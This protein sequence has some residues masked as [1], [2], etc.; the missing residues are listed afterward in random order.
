MRV[1][2][3]AGIF[4]GEGEMIQTDAKRVEVILARRVRIGSKQGDEQASHRHEHRSLGFP[5]QRAAEGVHVKAFG[6]RQIGDAQTQMAP[7]VG[8]QLHGALEHHGNLAQVPF[9]QKT[10]RHGFSCPNHQFVTKMW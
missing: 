9:P 4:D 5:H 2:E 3:L 1:C 7:A 6:P 8:A 10:Q